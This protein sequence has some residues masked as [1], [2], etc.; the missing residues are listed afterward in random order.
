MNKI[1]A[2]IFLYFIIPLLIFF[3]LPIFPQNIDSI[4][5]YNSTD[6]L[7]E[8]Y[9]NINK[10]LS[11]SIITQN[12]TVYVLNDSMIK[13]SYYQDLKELLYYFPGVF[14]YEL[15]N[16][17]YNHGIM[18][19]YLDHRSVEIHS[20]SISLNDPLTGTIDINDFPVEELDRI[21][22]LTTTK[23]FLYGFNSNA[24]VFNLRKKNWFY[25]RTFSKIRYSESA[26]EETS[27]DGIFSKNIQ[28]NWNIILG[29][30]RNATDGRYTNSEYDSWNLRFLTNYAIK[31]NINT[32]FSFVY[33]QNNVGTNGGVDLE[34]T[35]PL[36]TYDRLKAHVLYN[37]AYQKTSQNDI[38]LGITGNFLNN[39]NHIS[40]FILY[41]SN[42]MYYFN[43]P[44]SI[45]DTQLNRIKNHTR[46]IG[47]KLDHNV[48]LTNLLFKPEIKVGFE[49]RSSQI[50]QA[51]I[52]NYKRWAQ[53]KLTGDLK[54]SPLDIIK[55]NIFSRLLNFKH[56]NTTDAGLIVELNPYDI[57]SF[58]IGYSYSH[59][60][61]YDIEQVFSLIPEQSIS[62]EKHYTSELTFFL[63]PNS[64]TN[65]SLS[66]I[67][68]HIYDASVIQPNFEN[69]NRSNF[70]YA[71]YDKVQQNLIN[72]NI[73]ANIWKLESIINFAYNI[74]DFY[75]EPLQIH[76][77]F[78]LFSQI[79]FKEKLFNDKLFTKI[80]LRT[81]FYSEQ[82]SYRLDSRY[83][84]LYPNWGYILGNLFYLDA[85]LFLQI[86]NAIVNVALE[87]IFDNKCLL[88]YYFP[89]KDRSL[90][91]GINW[92]FED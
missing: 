13:F 60:F 87:N 53:G 18:I 64:S 52:L 50:L 65:I 72:L 41:L 68:K 84:I 66:Y 85:I 23:S 17:G 79:F 90:R 32:Y 15:G 8:N 36:D 82:D 40:S 35:N 9:L 63:K 77:R 61:Y 27:L 44:E 1:T 33:N 49:F 48:N 7:N 89:L 51:S 47:F 3:N 78:F 4:Y 71:T 55:I 31:N 54:I 25:T 29:F 26:Y 57:I 58:N 59:R 11:A 67:K 83:N 70:K 14:I 80:G 81:R 92:N 39:Q 69:N 74:K 73:N 56:I 5:I 28:N 45:T 34:K 24:G 20:N 22:Y 30:R 37:S 75:E 10:N 91:L 46:W 62:S 42:R 86:G 16:F 38:Q 12:E 43:N 19:N 76:P 2:K 88:T 6:T 21:E